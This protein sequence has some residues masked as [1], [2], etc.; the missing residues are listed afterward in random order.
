MPEISAAEWLI[1]L[2]AMLARSCIAGVAVAAIG[3]LAIALLHIITTSRT[4][5]RKDAGG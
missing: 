1:V 2:M 5:D 4:S 3:A